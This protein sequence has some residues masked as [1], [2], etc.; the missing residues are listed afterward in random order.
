MLFETSKPLDHA[1][2]Q[3][4]GEPRAAEAVRDDVSRAALPARPGR[5]RHPGPGA[6]DA[7]R[8]ADRRRVP[9]ADVPAADPVP[10]GEAPRASATGCCWRCAPRRWRSSSR[11]S[12]GPFCARLRARRRRPAARA[13]SWSC[14]TGP[15]AWA[16]ATAGPAPS[17][18]RARRCRAWARSTAGRSCCSRRR[19]S[20]S[21]GR[22]PMCRAWSPRSTRPSPSAGATRYAPALKVASSMLAESSLPRREVVLVSDFQRAG[23]QP[24]EAFRLP[25]G[26]VFTP[27]LVEPPVRAQPGRDAAVGAAGARPGRGARGHHGGVINRGAEPTS[28]VRP[29]A[30]SGRSCRAVGRR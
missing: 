6:P 13:R 29:D 25:V 28:R 14:S 9:V 19:R 3:L 20:S 12:R 11:R 2:F 27:V 30:R 10:V 8:A 18:R 24:D 15:T 22:A 5:A 17:R 1:L 21:C 26:S 16:P 23:W 7:A 4:P